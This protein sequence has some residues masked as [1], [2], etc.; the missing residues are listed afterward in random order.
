MSNLKSFVIKKVGGIDVWVYTRINDQGEIEFLHDS[1]W[2]S[3]ADFFNNY[4]NEI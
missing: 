4:Y 1:L 2:Y 3:G